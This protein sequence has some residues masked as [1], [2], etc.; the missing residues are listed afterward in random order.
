MAKTT[1]I[2]VDDWYIDTSI[3]PPYSYGQSQEWLDAKRLR[4]NG[5]GD[6][7]IISNNTVYFAKDS[8]IVTVNSVA[9]AI[10]TLVW[11][12]DETAT[13]STIVSQ[14]SINTA[15]AVTQEL[16]ICMPVKKWYYY[17]I[18]ST[19]WISNWYFTPIY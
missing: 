14:S 13:P 10:C 15:T 6:K 2:K 11:Y 19:T 17:K 7:Q 1:E 18:S 4:N 3:L 8:G 5:I 12:T 16:F 9:W